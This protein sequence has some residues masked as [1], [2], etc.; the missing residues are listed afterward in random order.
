MIICAYYGIETMLKNNIF[1]NKYIVMNPMDYKHREVDSII[2]WEQEYVGY[3]MLLDELGMKVVILPN[4]EVLK[5]IKRRKLDNIIYVYPELNQKDSWVEYLNGRLLADET[6]NNIDGLVRA[7][8][9]YEYD[10]KQM[11]QYAKNGHSME[12]IN[13]DITPIVVLLEGD[14]FGTKYESSLYKYVWALSKND[15]EPS[16]LSDNSAEVVKDKQT[17]EYYLTLDNSKDATNIYYKLMEYISN[18]EYRDEIIFLPNKDN[19]SV[20]V[21]EGELAIWGKTLSDLILG[22]TDYSLTSLQEK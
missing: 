19:Y 21:Y 18:S 16:L 15:E 14:I 1:K 17:G 6:N 9:N 12:V 11:K 8:Y 20:T 22:L 4:E 3:A 5:E 2:P 13:K 10:I 7:I